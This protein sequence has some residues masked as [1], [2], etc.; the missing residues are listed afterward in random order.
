MLGGVLSSFR[1]VAQ[2]FRNIIITISYLSILWNQQTRRSEISVI[3]LN[4]AL[5]FLLWK[6]LIQIAQFHS[7]Y[8]FNSWSP[9]TNVIRILDFY[10]AGVGCS[11][12]LCIVETSC[13]C[14]C[15]FCSVKVDHENILKPTKCNKRMAW[16]N[17][18]AEEGA[19]NGGRQQRLWSETDPASN[20][21]TIKY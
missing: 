2:S 12:R 10:N 3:S 16:K 17:S 8:E 6:I 7:N 9:Q 11:K 5:S 21:D 4:I 1:A 14:S 18:C 19:M 20:R 13:F 15:T